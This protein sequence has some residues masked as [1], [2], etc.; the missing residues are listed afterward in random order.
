M[1]RDLIQWRL[2]LLN[3]AFERFAEYTVHGTWYGT[4]ADVV[5]PATT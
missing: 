4:D 1:T 2:L 3:R 5:P